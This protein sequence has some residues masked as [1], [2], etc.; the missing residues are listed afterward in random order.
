MK[1]FEIADAP[2]PPRQPSIAALWFLLS[3]DLREQL[4]Q[5]AAKNGR[6]IVDEIEFRLRRDLE[7]EAMGPRRG[8]R[9]RAKR[10]INAPG[11]A[12]QAAEVPT[13]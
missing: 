2:T 7:H 6:F 3:R 13:W 1:R 5:S 10:K 11:R 12:R 8:V 4:Q 9:I